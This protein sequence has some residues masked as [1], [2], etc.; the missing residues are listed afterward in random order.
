MVRK[1]DLVALATFRK[2]LRIFVR[3]VEE[4]ARAVGV[5]P[6]QHQLLL[7]VEGNA[8][9]SWATVGELAGALQL[10]HHATVGLVNRCQ[11]A[12]LVS[13]SPDPEDRRV[14]H[15]S[16]T[17]KGSS[18]LLELTER[19]LARLQESL[20]GLSSEL[21]TLAREWRPGGSQDRRSSRN[22][23]THDPGVSK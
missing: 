7:A 23:T 22:L 16:L 17:P 10:K 12:G 15:V 14:V 2:A 5:T 11:A 20:R 3:F 9:R 8:G 4:G 18:I 13:R 19:N 6:Q 21:D 1:E